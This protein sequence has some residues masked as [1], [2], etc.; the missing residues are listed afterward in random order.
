MEEE[1]QEMRPER[2][3]PPGAVDNPSPACAQNVIH[4]S[5]EMGLL[6]VIRDYS[7][8]ARM[9]TFVLLESK[10]ALQHPAVSRSLQ[11]GANGKRLP[12]FKDG[13]I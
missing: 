11:L 9:D 4:H 12:L 1:E 7:A 13:I 8:S 10:D 5:R 6:W 2:P 3:V